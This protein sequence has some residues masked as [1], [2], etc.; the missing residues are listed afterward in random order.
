MT[1]DCLVLIGNTFH[2]LKSLESCF[3][4]AGFGPPNLSDKDV[5]KA[6]C[7]KLRKEMGINEKQRSII[8]K[9]KKHI[10]SLEDEVVKL[11]YLL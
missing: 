11:E 10:S 8:E 4:P 3:E 5:G 2:L 9:M 1:D 7:I 6:L